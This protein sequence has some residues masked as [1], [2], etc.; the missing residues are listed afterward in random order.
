MFSAVIELHRSDEGFSYAALGQYFT[1][2]EAGRIQSLIRKRSE[3]AN[4]NIE[5]LESSVN[6]LKAKKTLAEAEQSGDKFAV[7]RLKRQKTR[8][9]QQKQ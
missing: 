2:E 5:I 4:N 9:E 6:T 3:L 8:R 1:S 7:I